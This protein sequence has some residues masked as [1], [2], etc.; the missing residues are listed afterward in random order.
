MYTRRQPKHK[1]SATARGWPGYRV[2]ALL[3][4]Y[5]LAFFSISLF[6]E[7]TYTTSTTTTTNNNNNNNSDKTKNNNNDNDNNSRGW[8]GYRVLAEL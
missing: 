3:I 2:L 7:K 8:P 4:L 6:H 1:K 5:F